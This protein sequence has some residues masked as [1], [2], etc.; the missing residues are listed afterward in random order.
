MVD[1]NDIYLSIKINYDGDKKEI[2][3][4]DLLT[5]DELKQ[6]IISLFKLKDFTNKDIDLFFVNNSSKTEPI[7]NNEELFFEAEEINEYLYS[8]EIK[9]ISKKAEKKE[10]LLKDL[11]DIKEIKKRKRNLV[12][13]IEKTKIDIECNKKIKKMK[14][15]IKYYKYLEDLKKTLHEKIYEEIK[16]KISNKHEEKNQIINTM[17]ESLKK[18]INAE[19]NKKKEEL[20]LQLDNK[21]DNQEKIKLEPERDK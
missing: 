20:F 19:I 12:F 14:R 10:N 4:K 15:K 18:N 3:I 8:I 17:K 9:F 13:E 2:R 6:E 11:E 5:I 1:K 16:T 7:S 21:T